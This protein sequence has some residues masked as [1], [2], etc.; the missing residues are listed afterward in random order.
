MTTNLVNR[1]ATVYKFH[2]DIDDLSSIVLTKSSY[3]SF[4]AQHQP[5]ISALNGD[6]ITKTFVFLGYSFNDPDLFHILQNIA[7]TYEKNKRKHYAIFKKLQ[8]N[9]FKTPDD[10]HYQCVKRSLKIEDLKRYGIETLEVS[11]YDQIPLLFDSIKTKY[12]LNNIYIAGSS[13]KL[14]DNWDENKANN[15]LYQLGYTLAHENYKICTGCIEGV[16]PQIENGVLNAVVEH[17]LN[18]SKALDIKRLPLI[19]GNLDHMNDQ[20]KEVMR[21]D[22]YEKNGI[23]IFLFGNQTYDNGRT[24]EASNGVLNDF[25]RAKAKK[26]YIIPVGSTGGASEK[27]LEEVTKNICEYPYLKGHLADLSSLTDPTELVELILT[28]IQSIKK[29]QLL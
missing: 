24:Y 2:G 16:G 18:L 8:P 10:Y 1:D 23:A 17:N 12:L 3:E 19:D 11:D 27:I 15:F 29:I 7:L 4:S 9:D 20:S 14:P 26:M 5:F 22:I 21:K 6:L 28:I 25:R 13:R